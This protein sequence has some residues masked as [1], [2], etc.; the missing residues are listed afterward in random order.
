M[1]RKEYG[2]YLINNYDNFCRVREIIKNMDRN[3]FTVDI[4]NEKK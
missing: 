2:Q 3:Y 4:I 1:D